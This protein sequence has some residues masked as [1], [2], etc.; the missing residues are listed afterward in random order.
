MNLRGYHVPETAVILRRDSIRPRL[1]V[2]ILL[3]YR[4][5]LRERTGAGEY[6]HEMARAL[7]ATAP[8]DE[9]L[10]LFSASWKD[11]LS[12]EAVPGLDVVD[13]QIPVRVLNFAWHRLAWPPVEHLAG[14]RFDVVQSAHPLLMPS[15]G[16]ARS[17]RSRAVHACRR[18]G[19]TWTARETASRVRHRPGR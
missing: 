10:V 14:R 3:D 17:R 6:V 7:A 18:S 12:H 16:A 4:P 9:A 13:R 5:A 2:R 1:S 11:R 8:A 15:T 19:R